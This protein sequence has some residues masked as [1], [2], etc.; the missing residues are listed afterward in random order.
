MNEL[1]KVL[2]ED[3]NENLVQTVNARD[4]HEYLEVNTR[5]DIWIKRRIEEGDFQESV[6]YLM[7]KK[8]HQVN[9][10]GGVR[11]TRVNGSGQVF[12]YNLLKKEHKEGQ[13]DD[14]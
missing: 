5:F 9:H 7:F 8:D 6:D 13:I 1:V 4:L 11:N 10:Q 14:K 2:E 3:I 12:F